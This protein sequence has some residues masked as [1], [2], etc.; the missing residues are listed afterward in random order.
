MKNKIMLSLL[1]IILVLSSCGDKKSQQQAMGLMSF[2]VQKVVKGD[3]IIYQEY[4]AS[5]E[6]QQN[7]EI[8][9]KV[10]GFIEKIYV[11]EGQAVKKGQVLFQLETQ[12]LTQDADAAKAAI[13]VAQVEVNKLIPLVERKIVGNVLLE[14]AKANL[15]Q[16]KANYNAINSN[17]NFATI[18]SPVN[19]FIGSIPYK[20]GSLVSST[21][22]DPLT[23]VSDIRNIRAYFTM[24]EKQ[25]INFNK[26]FKGV[27][28]ADK[29]KVLPQVELILA[30]NSVYNLKGKIETINGLVNSR[31]GS[32]KLRA[33]FPNP[34]SVLRSGGSGIIRLPIEEKNVILLPQ[35][36]VFE[37]Q[38][39]Q[40][41]FVVGKE[42]KVEPKII[43]TSGTFGLN[44]IV[45]GGVEAGELV[46]IEGAT[47]LT[48][49][50]EIVPQEVGIKNSKETTTSAPEAKPQVK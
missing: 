50:Q 16:A 12:T 9:P 49:G 35:N 40:M 7:V 34:Q 46:V 11:D 20:V 28:T 38:G 41:I 23:T 8:K 3:V 22:V 5:L 10:T 42:N 19:G 29:I 14:T 13:N 37:M 44:Y 47:K 31:T 17:I 25:I 18:T 45:T 36:A 33:Q 24:N 21:I 26:T 6:G 32:T 4:S 27:T 43:Q 30:D 15:A 39:K 2:P 48:N 1:L